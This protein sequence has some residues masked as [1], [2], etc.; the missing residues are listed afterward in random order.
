MWKKLRDPVAISYFKPQVGTESLLDLAAAIQSG[1][2]TPRFRPCRILQRGDH[3]MPTPQPIVGN[4]VTAG[5]KRRSTRL[6]GPV[7]RSVRACVAFGVRGHYK[8]RSKLGSDE[9]PH[10]DRAL[11]ALGE[12]PEWQRGGTVNPLAYAFVG[13]SPTSPTT[14]RSLTLSRRLFRAPIFRGYSTV[15]VQQPSKLNMRVRFPLP[16]PTLRLPAGTHGQREI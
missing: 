4:R 15:V 9:I 3:S 8:T 14:R 6:S 11:S 7:F 10:L 16:A 13:S 5:P 12:C 1:Q 2:E